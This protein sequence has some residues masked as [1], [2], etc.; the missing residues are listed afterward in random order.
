MNQLKKILEPENVAGIISGLI[1]G[2]ILIVIAMALSGLIFTGPLEMFLPQG[3]GILLFGFLAYSIFSIFSASHPININTPQDIPI[4][5][6]ALIAASVMTTTGKSWDAEMSF[7]F[8]FVTIALTSVLVGVFFLIMGSLRLGKLVRFIPYP[9]V[10]G[11]LAGTGWLII[12]FAFAMTAGVELSISNLT[13]L[14]DQSNFVRWFPGLLFGLLLLIGSLYTSHYLL[15]PGVITAGIVLFYVLMTFNGYSF[16]ELQDKGYLLGPFPDGGL[17]QG[18]PIK[19]LSTFKWSVF[20]DQLPSIGTMMFLN[21]I[22]L[23]FNYSGLEL[24]IKKDLDLDREL[25]VTGCGNIIAGIFGA[26]PGHLALGSSSLA[27]SIGAKNRLSTIIVAIMCGSTL[28][29][30]SKVLTII[31]KIILGGLLFNLGLSFLM[32]WVVNTWNRVS[33][34]DYVVIILILT[35]IGTIGF[36]EGV[37]AGLMASVI[38]FVVNYSKVQSIKYTLTGKNFH[39]NVE[40]SE[41]MKNII[42]RSGNQ[43]LILPLQGYLFF[44]SANRLI[45]YIKRF[46]ETDEGREL[47]Y[48]IFD[49]R[50]ITG[51]DSSAINSF[52]KLKILATIHNFRVLFCDIRTQTYSKFESEGLFENN[53][54]NPFMNFEDLDYGM[55]WCEEM[56]IKSEKHSSNEQ[57]SDSMIFERQFPNLLPYLNKLELDK[58]HKIIEKGSDPKGLY[59]IKSGKV[60]IELDSQD[61]KRIRLKSSGAGTIVGEVSLYLNKN[62]T[63]SVVTD[64]RCEVYYLSVKNFEKLKLEA[65]D[66][67]TKLHTYVI[68]LLSDRLTK[69]N[70]TI[71]ALMK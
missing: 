25:K 41:K 43:I 29:F 58:N 51:T 23:L 15:V 31:P 45:D 34:G 30:G 16:L 48:L 57:K 1:N 36:L 71:Q 59:F 18:S 70:N 55:E 3:I 64:E 8:I 37:L 11:F 32:E 19:Y 22:S 27:H 20:I 6:I 2:I 7:Q 13:F 24:I 5:I 44:G 52:N 66:E 40:R 54:S 47:R 14:L 56:I 62:A 33:K 65:S 53:K 9:V 35:V 28:F 68:K 42:E 17:F 46:L 4:A 69:T 26:P 38:M 60:T 10:G 49:L 50:Q 67:A 39:S 21:A 63:A 61:G 12:K